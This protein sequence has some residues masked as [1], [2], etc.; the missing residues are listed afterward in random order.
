MI[1]R[2]DLH[3][4]SEVATNCKPSSEGIFPVIALNIT[5]TPSVKMLKVAKR[6]RHSAWVRFTASCGTQRVGW[7]R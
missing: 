4:N 5:L 1:Q 7:E 2:L 3:K 6:I